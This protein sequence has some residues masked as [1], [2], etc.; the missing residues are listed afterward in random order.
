MELLT[1]GVLAGFVWLTINYHWPRVIACG[2]I[3]LVWGLI[4]VVGPI[5]IF[6]KNISEGHFSSAIMVIV[7][8]MVMIFSW[9]MAAQAAYRWLQKNELWQPWNAN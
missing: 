6:I 7:V 4:V 3:L 8:S 9:L 1:L 5:L 2:G